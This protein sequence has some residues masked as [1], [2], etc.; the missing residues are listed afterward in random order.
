[1]NPQF[2]ELPM[3]FES[4]M[5]Q[6][7]QDYMEVVRLAATEPDMALLAPILQILERMQNGERRTP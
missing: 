1:L 6:L 2:T 7:V 3:V 5:S 4:L